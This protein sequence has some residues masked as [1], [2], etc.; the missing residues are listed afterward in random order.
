VPRA[1]GGAARFD[2]E[3]LCGNAA[4]LGAADYLALTQR[5]H[6]VLIEGV[7]ILSDGNRNEAARFVSLVDALYDNRCFLGMTAAAPLE[8]LLVG[9][10]PQMSEDGAT[11]GEG[12]SIDVAF[13]GGSS[14][15]RHTT[16]LPGN[17]EWSA[18]GLHGASLANFGGAEHNETVFA[19]SRT[20]SR[21]VE[22]QGTAFV[23]R[24]TMQT[25][26]WSSDLC[27]SHTDAE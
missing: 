2:F 12:V 7:P 21:L 11:Q 24:T 15:G 18:T 25:G 16:I 17:V 20:R 3:A 10:G 9:D 4:A 22:M 13:E 26:R 14:S 6:S 5:F 19:F 1:R 8:K 23:A 27:L